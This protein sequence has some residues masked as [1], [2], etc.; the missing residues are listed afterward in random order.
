MFCDIIS[1]LREDEAFDQLDKSLHSRR[2]LLT[3]II[4]SIYFDCNLKK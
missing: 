4:G 1:P 3:N 2:F